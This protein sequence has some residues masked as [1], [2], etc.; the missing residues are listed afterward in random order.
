MCFAWKVRQRKLGID[1]FGN[2]L[3]SPFPSDNSTAVQIASTG[4]LDPDVRSA[5]STAPGT[6]GERTPLLAQQQT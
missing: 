5:D 6:A 2:S 3:H 1:D 4:A